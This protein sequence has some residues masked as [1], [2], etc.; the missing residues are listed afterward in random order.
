[1]LLLLQVGGLGD[2]VTS[3][4]KAHQATGTL[5]EVVLP[6]YDCAH[7]GC[8]PVC[9]NGSGMTQGHDTLCSCSWERRSPVQGSTPASAHCVVSEHQKQ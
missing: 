2:V 4:A 3:L 6:K 1:M 8:V 9:C 7:Y 5:V